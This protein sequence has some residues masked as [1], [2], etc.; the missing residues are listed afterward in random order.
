MLPPGPPPNQSTLHHVEVELQQQQQQQD[1]S[2]SENTGAAAGVLG[3]LRA[4]SRDGV[5]LP[6]SEEEE[7]QGGGMADAVRRK[8]PKK[9]TKAYGRSE[10]ATAIDG[11]AGSSLKDDEEGDGGKEGDE[12]VVSTCD[13]DEI[14]AHYV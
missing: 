13:P 3:R 9:K 14:T 12:N 1:N 11:G 8:S 5:A 2:S 6:A 7:G 4:R 10:V